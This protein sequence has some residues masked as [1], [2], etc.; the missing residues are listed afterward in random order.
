M[1]YISCGNVTKRHKR[2]RGSQK[3]AWVCR[4]EK[5]LEAHIIST[6]FE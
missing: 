2:W 4:I 5:M 1:G 6:N 3:V